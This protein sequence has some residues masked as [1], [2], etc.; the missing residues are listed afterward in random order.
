MSRGTSHGVADS[1]GTVA[2][3]DDACWSGTTDQSR[4]SRLYN[5]F[6]RSTLHVS[7]QVVIGGIQRRITVDVRGER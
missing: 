7:W 6:S 4:L 1:Q 5:S 2:R 3:S